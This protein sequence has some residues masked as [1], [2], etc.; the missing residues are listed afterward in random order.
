MAYMTCTFSPDENEKNVEWFLKKFPAFE[1][2]KV[3]F[4][5]TY[6]SHLA[7]FA[8]YRMWPH[9]SPAAGSF[10]VLLKNKTETLQASVSKHSDLKPIWKS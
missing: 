10:T 6:R 8:C 1:A 5:E 4:L 3:D 7:D 2:V 9:K